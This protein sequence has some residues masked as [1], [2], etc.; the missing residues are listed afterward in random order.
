MAIATYSCSDLHSCRT[1]K[2]NALFLKLGFLQIDKQQKKFI[3]Y[4]VWQCSLSKVGH[5][6]GL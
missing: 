6:P 1:K 4:H 3:Y 2:I 5:S